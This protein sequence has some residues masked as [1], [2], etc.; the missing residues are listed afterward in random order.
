MGEFKQ[1]QVEHS[2][3]CSCSFLKNQVWILVKN[4]LPSKIL[5]RHMNMQSSVRGNQSCMDMHPTNIQLNS[6]PV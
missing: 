5:Q 6:L 1:K 2:F 3:R 4:F